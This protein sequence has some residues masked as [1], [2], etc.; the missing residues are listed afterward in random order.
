MQIVSGEDSSDSLR[1]LNT[2]NSFNLLVS[3][4]QC[5]LSTSCSPHPV[6]F[7]SVSWKARK[8]IEMQTL[9]YCYLRDLIKHDCWDTMCVKERVVKVTS[10][11]KTFS[12]VVYLFLKVQRQNHTFVICLWC[13]KNFTSSQGSG[14]SFILLI[15][16]ESCGFY[17]LRW[18]IVLISK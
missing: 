17:L 12:A 4:T 8:E 18:K 14:K 10:V 9:S 2:D 1:W 7:P 11:S 3:V 16:S 13:E 15:L 6:I 5:K